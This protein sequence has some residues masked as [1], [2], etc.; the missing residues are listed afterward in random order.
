[1]SEQDAGS[2]EHERVGWYVMQSHTAVV[3]L[4]SVHAW[5]HQRHTPLSADLVSELMKGFSALWTDLSGYCWFGTA[6]RK[7]R[8]RPIAPNAEIGPKAERWV[9]QMVSEALQAA[10]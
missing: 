6:R 7:V 2:T 1:M 5:A 9:S 8:I 4:R 10:T 3:W